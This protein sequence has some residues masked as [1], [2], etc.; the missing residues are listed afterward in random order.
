MAKVRGRPARYP[1]ELLGDVLW[2]FCRPTFRSLSRFEAAVR[3][4]YR[5]M[6]WEFN[7]RPEA[8]VLPCQRVRV[9][10]VF[11]DDY[12]PP[13]DQERFIAELAADSPSGFKAGELLFK[14]HNLFLRRWE[15]DAGDYIYF[16]GFR[17]VKDPAGDAPPLYSIDV[18]S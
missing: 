5:E 16:E 14:V 6:G 2:C 15:E 1:R 9:R 13:M 12:V 4:Y 11:W 18:G 17:L 7:W 3:R 8:V 10:P